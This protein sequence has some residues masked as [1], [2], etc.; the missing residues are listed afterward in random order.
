M[1]V[2][3]IED[4][5]LN[6]RVV[7]EMLHIGGVEMSEAESG[8]AGLEMVAR[9][10]A[11]DLLLV[12]LRMPGM[13]GF[14]AIR[15]IRARDDEKADVPMIVVTADTGSDLSEQCAAAGADDVLQKPVSMNALFEAIARVLNARGGGGALI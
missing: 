11:Y 10:E 8:E 9:E 13:D 5:P 7:R 3:F 6:R 14:E 1:K 15:R 12:D 4:N 2:L